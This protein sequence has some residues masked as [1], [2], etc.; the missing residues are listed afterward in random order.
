MK[1][2]QIKILILTA[3]P[4][5]TDS[6]SLGVEVRKIEEALQRARNRDRFEVIPRLAV[7]TIDLRRALLDHRPQIV[8]FSG[9]GA[10]KGLVLENDAGKIQLVSTEALAR[11]FGAFEFGEIECVLLNA[12]YS[13]VQAA[14]I[15]QY[16]DCVIGMHQPI[17]D[18]AAIQFAEGFYDALGAGSSYEEAHKV[19]CSA[20]DLEGIKNSGGISESLIPV[21][22]ARRR[23]TAPESKTVDLPKSIAYPENAKATVPQANPSQSISISGGTISGQVAQAGGN[24][25]Q[26]QQINQ[27]LAEPQL[28]VTEVLELI[29]LITA[30]FQNSTLPDEQKHKATTHLE[31]AKESAKEKEPDKDY[32]AKSLQKATKL[33][34]D[35]NETVE[36]GQ[37][38]WNKVE[39]MLKQLVPWLGVAS[40]FLGL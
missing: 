15:H 13:E 14:A 40:H 20:I 6:L 4:K 35:T 31:A 33:L 16:V 38:L 23:R 36:V 24:V 8:H 10:E 9:H 19:G 1:N 12:C 25:T 32:V 7:R 5:G 39:P 3:N 28:T 2:Q 34:K 30:L 37:G 21:I 26:A 17:G 18:R 29:T 27:G 22:Q 11:L